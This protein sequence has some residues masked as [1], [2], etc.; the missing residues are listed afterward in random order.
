MSI[1][2]IDEAAFALNFAEA[3]QMPDKV[4]AILVPAVNSYLTNATGKDWA[5]ITT[6]YSAIDPLAK[7]VASV[8][9]AQWYED[10]TQVGT[11]AGGGLLGM[12]GQLHA[13]NLQEQAAC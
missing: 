6:A 9:L 7:M 4:M 1:L 5:V 8:V 12:I 11:V 3:E 2:S 13:K 10:P